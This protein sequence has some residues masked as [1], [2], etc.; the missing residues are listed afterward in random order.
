MLRIA[1]SNKAFRLL[2]MFTPLQRLLLTL[3][4]IVAIAASW[5]LL[6]YRPLLIRIESCQKKLTQ[7]QSSETA[8]NELHSKFSELEKTVNALENR[9]AT[10][11]VG[12][13]KIMHSVEKI[14][15]LAHQSTVCIDN[16]RL[17]QA[18]AKPM[19]TVIPV[20]MQGHGSLVQLTN[21]FSSLFKTY[22]NMAPS[23]INVDYIKNDIFQF[24]VQLNLLITT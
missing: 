1:R 2:L 11:K 19:V 6:L 3:C 20:I 10:I 14:I 23:Q 24:N 22:S 15:N 7:N 5:Y 17:E 4:I 13:E 21:F 8:C 16:C 18:E 12:D 9:I